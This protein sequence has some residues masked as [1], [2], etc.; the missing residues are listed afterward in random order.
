MD[1]YAIKPN[2]A[3]EKPNS[4]PGIQDFGSYFEL[5]TLKT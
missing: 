1:A 3:E 5:S 2:E 4:E